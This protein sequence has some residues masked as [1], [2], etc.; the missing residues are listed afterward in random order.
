MSDA[1]GLAVALAVPVVAEEER[2]VPHPY[3][4]AVGLPTI[5][6]GRRIPSMHHAPVTE[7]DERAWMADSLAAR[8]HAILALSPVL[9]TEPAHRLA[10]LMS[11]AYNAGTNAYAGS[12]L[13]KKVAARD[14]TGA[15][16]EFGKWVYGHKPDGTPVKLGGLVA[17]RAREAMLFQGKA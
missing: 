1:V 10:A 3:L 12:T 4:D 7:A 13:R 15:V 9:G 6:Y 11:F 17:R 16:A 14:W 8:G 2:F 5:G